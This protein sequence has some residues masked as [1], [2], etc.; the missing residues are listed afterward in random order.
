[1]AVDFIQSCL[2][3]RNVI[4][5]LNWEIKIRIW[6]EW[7]SFPSSWEIHVNARCCVVSF[8]YYQ[9]EGLCKCSIAIKHVLSIYNDI[10]GVFFY[11]Y[12][13]NRYL[14]GALDVPLKLSGCVSFFQ[15]N[16]DSEREI[17]MV[18][19]TWLMVIDL[20]LF[21]RKKEG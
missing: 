5:Y 4:V 11:I 12:F 8:I 6:T 7:M 19:H 15:D 14:K 3:K 2:K 16:A 20:M 9:L 1:M 18:N 10:R 13:T 17:C 21:C